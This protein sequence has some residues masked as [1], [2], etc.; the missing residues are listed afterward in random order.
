MRKVAIML[1]VL[2]LVS[3]AAIT[4]ETTAK[5]GEIKGVLLDKKT[6]APVVGW[7]VLLCMANQPMV[8]CLSEPLKQQGLSDA[9]GRFNIKGLPPG[10]YIIMAGLP[11]GTSGISFGRYSIVKTAVNKTSVDVVIQKPS[12]VIDL[13]KILVEP[14]EL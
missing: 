8:N 5:G 13:G 14:E 4:Q 6:N 9:S 3:L 10:T 7:Q 2:S 11:A 12:D 1:L